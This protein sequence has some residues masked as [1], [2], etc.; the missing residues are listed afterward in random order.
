MAAP[1][2]SL[3]EGRYG[4]DVRSPKTAELLTRRLRRM[5]VTGE[6]RDGDY[7][8]REAELMTHF[9]VSRP[10]L[11]E[12]VRVLEAESLVEV[13]RGSRTGARIRVPGPE[14]VARPAGLLLAVAGTTLG[15]VLAARLGIEPLAAW[16]VADRGSDDA[17]EELVAA[18][19]DLTAR[20]AQDVSSDTVGTAFARFHEVVVKQSGNRALV[21]TAGMIQEILARHMATATRTHYE[22]EPDEVQLQ[23]RRAVR[24][25]EKLISLVRAGEADEAERFWRRHLISANE[26]LLRGFDAAGVIDILE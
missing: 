4:A 12:A 10:T 16:L 7:L 5:I 26:S 22:S 1:V 23:Y 14:V 17:I 3:P 8:P 21:V 20:L 2:F 25:Y 13:R 9:G 19:D 11:R 18:L 6:L 24:A 15:E